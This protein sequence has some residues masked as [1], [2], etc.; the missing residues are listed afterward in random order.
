VTVLPK[1]APQDLILS[2]NRFIPD[3]NNFFQAIGNF[4]V[5]DQVDNV[6]SI[7]LVQGELDNGFFEIKDNILFWSSAEQASGKSQFS[8]KVQVTDRDGNTLVKDFTI[9]RERVVLSTLEVYNSFSP[10]GDGFNDTWGVPDLRYFRNVKVHIFNIEGR[11]V[12]Y[13]KN[14]DFRW[15]GTFN[16]VDLANDTFQWVIEIEETGEKRNGYLHLI[17]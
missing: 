9:I 14:P 16:G 13:T 6:D 10:N 1:P 12:F 3:P 8:I 7:V 4:S 2:N 17:R 11:R 5:V 15:N